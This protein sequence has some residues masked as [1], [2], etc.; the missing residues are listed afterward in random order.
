MRVMLHRHPHI[1]CGP[2]SQL[3]EQ[4]GFMQ[5]HQYM[6]TTWA[7][8]LELFGLDGRDL[9][10][11]MAAFMD[12]FLSRYAAQRGKK[13][14]GEKTPKNILRI[15]YLFRLFPNARFIHMIRDPRDVHCS[16][17]EKAQTTTARWSDITADA[18][19][20]GWV[21]SI[22]RGIPWRDDFQRYLEVR[23]E[24][25]T[26]D[27]AGVM[28]CV[29]EFLDEPWSD[30]V[31]KARAANPLFARGNVNQ[32]V[33]TTSVERWRQD[34]SNNEIDAI[35]AIAGPH[36]QELGYVPRSLGMDFPQSS[37]AGGTA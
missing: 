34:L 6:S 16:V 27:A 13:R 15:D 22:G 20:R 26:R 12:D 25:L 30:A 32:Q 24:D 4:T 2:E 8:S 7:P 28:R 9:D 36:M 10:G 11:A 1:A 35:E 18:T 19:A 37:L 31:L 33:F 5:F 17:K 21:K 29:L 3:L 14:W 23:Y